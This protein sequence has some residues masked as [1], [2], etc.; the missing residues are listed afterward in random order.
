MTIKSICAKIFAIRQEVGKESRVY[1]SEP[2]INVSHRI[3][4]IRVQ[5]KKWCFILRHIFNP[6]AVGTLG[7]ICDAATEFLP[8]FG[9]RIALIL[10]E[11]RETNY[12]FQ[13]F[14]VLIQRYNAVAFRG[15]F[16]ETETES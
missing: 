15:S 10:N 2:I 1:C 8:G 16:E 3:F 12:P 13:R 5:N 9:R 7:T 4:I 14:S 6:V 11:P